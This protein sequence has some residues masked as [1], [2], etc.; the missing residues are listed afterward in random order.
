MPRSDPPALHGRPTAHESGS[1]P[2]RAERRPGRPSLQPAGFSFTL[3]RTPASDAERAF[4]AAAIV[5]VLSGIAQPDP[6]R[7]SLKLV[8]N[9]DEL[10]RFAQV[11]MPLTYRLLDERFFLEDLPA[12]ARDMVATG[13]LPRASLAARRRSRPPTKSSENDRKAGGRNGS[14]AQWKLMSDQ[15]PRKP[16]NLPNRP[17]TGGRRPRR[18]G[19]ADT[20]ATQELFAALGQPTPEF[21]DGAVV[22]RF[23]GEDLPADNGYVY[24]DGDGMLV[25]R[26]S[27]DDVQKHETVMSGVHAMHRLAERLDLRPREILVT[28]RNSGTRR[29]ENRPDFAL[30]ERR[31]AAGEINWVAFR[32]PDRIGRDLFPTMQFYDLLK[33]T[34]TGLY[35]CTIGDRV[36][37]RRHRTLLGIQGVIAEDE[38]SNIRE[39]TVGAIERRWLEE[40]RGWPT[41][42]KYGFRRDDH[43]FLEVDPEAWEWIK[44]IHYGYSSFHKDGKAS[45]RRLQQD[46]AGQG[47]TISVNRLRG[48]LHDPMY[49]TGEWTVQHQGEIIACRPVQLEDPIPFDIFNTNQLLL[50]A[51]RG[52]HTRTAVGTFLLNHI[53]L[54]HAP[55]QNEKHGTGWIRLKARVDHRA[56]DAARYSHSQHTPSQCKGYTLPAAELDAAVIRALLEL[57]ESDELMEAWWHRARA[58]VADSTPYLTPEKAAQL[59]TQVDTLNHQIG[60]A[61]TQYADKVAAGQTV[62]ADDF[63]E[64]TKALRIRRDQL[65]R[66]LEAHRGHAGAPAP[67]QDGPDDLALRLREVLTEHT[68]ADP[69]K[70]LKRAA[71]VETAV[72]KIIVHDNDDCISLEIHGWLINERQLVTQKP[73]LTEHLKTTLLSR[74]TNASRQPQEP[75]TE[76]KGADADTDDDPA[77]PSEIGDLERG[78]KAAG[79]SESAKC[80]ETRGNPT[81]EAL[82]ANSH[83]GT[84]YHQSAP[85]R[86]NPAHVPVAGPALVA[87]WQ[88][89]KHRTALTQRLLLDDDQRLGELGAA[90]EIY[91]QWRIRR[92]GKG[93]PAFHSGQLLIPSIRPLVN[94]RPGLW[95]SARSIAWAVAALRPESNDVLG[96]VEVEEFLLEQRRNGFAV[97]K[98]GPRLTQTLSADAELS[99]DD[100]IRQAVCFYGR[101]FDGRAYFDWRRGVGKE[102]P[103]RR[104]ARSRGGATDLHRGAGPLVPPASVEQARKWLFAHPYSP[105]SDRELTRTWSAAEAL[106]CARDGLGWIHPGRMFGPTGW[107]LQLER[108]KGFPTSVTLSNTLRPL[109]L[110]NV[111]LVPLAEDRRWG[112]WRFLKPAAS[113]PALEDTAELL[114]WL[115]AQLGVTIPDLCELSGVLRAN[116]VRWAEATSGLPGP[117][118]RARLRLAARVVARLWDLPPLERLGWWHERQLAL[119]G[120]TPLEALDAEDPGCFDAILAAAGS[121]QLCLMPPAGQNGA[122]A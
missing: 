72:S 5:A 30:I 25:H 121:R 35:L 51:T 89:E 81:S 116:A 44:K 11:E 36:D 23:R 59:Q 19:T 39:R 61:G 47:F 17:G 14:R 69:A 113:A 6:G 70:R 66:R 99:A 96:L 83:T 40:G 54:R 85:V 79:D 107:K 120:R 84:E 117:V 97:S 22:Y 24:A 21:H 2:R 90:Q 118:A 50:Q 43:N 58:T 34:N 106:D 104:A 109:F 112:Q 68:P 33:R 94:V 7:P 103:L 32:A 98:H 56:S 105:V 82:P 67:A 73:S 87:D 71:L 37:W 115:S 52:K 101:A 86:E 12:S 55:C 10:A 114:A 93:F 31:I 16:A 78:G 60:E 65:Q 75:I 26:L 100:L 27:S 64:M 13:H 111:D 20:L 38:H 28:M 108:R 48:I 3:H 41:S 62:S 80:P 102:S 91:G 74:A 92:A 95:S 77:E 8:G 46:L 88:N 29:Y 18:N 110:T 9:R 63:A 1:R 122:Q 57:A 4:R 15:P 45:L 76:T 119:G 49:T 42:I 53:D